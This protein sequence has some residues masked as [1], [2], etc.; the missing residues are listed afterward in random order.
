M[1]AVLGCKGC[2]TC[3]SVCPVPDAIVR[4]G[5]RVLK[6]REDICRKCHE[7]VK[8]CPYGALVVMD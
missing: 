2:K 8:V 6:I 3:D 5:G 1:I 7:C 4:N